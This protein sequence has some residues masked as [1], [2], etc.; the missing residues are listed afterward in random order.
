MNVAI[1][2]VYTIG[3]IIICGAMFWVVRGWYISSARIIKHLEGVSEYQKRIYMQR[4][5][6][7]FFAV[8]NFLPFPAKSP[9]FSHLSS[10][11]HGIP[12]IRASNAESI[13]ISEFDSHQVC[14]LFNNVLQRLKKQLTVYFLNVI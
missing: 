8:T 10:T 7:F 3:A 4:Y 14:N 11:L 9:V 6:L 13:L 2:N 1:S 12:T 5:N